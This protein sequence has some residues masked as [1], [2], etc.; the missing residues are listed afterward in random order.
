MKQL[1]LGTYTREEIAKEFNLETSN[2]NFA[3]KVKE[4]LTKWGYSFEYSRKQ[5]T[6]TRIPTTADEKL[7]EILIREYGLDIQTETNAF[8]AFFYS[9]VV[10][11]EFSSMPWEERAEFLED[12]FG[13]CVSDRTLRSW[14]S[15]LLQT[16]T[17]VKDDS[18]K[19]R[20]ITGYYQG[21]KYR[22]LVDGDKELEK[23]ADDYRK[24]MKELLDKYKT[25]ENKEKWSL[26]RKELWNKYKCCIYYCNTLTTTAFDNTESLEILQEMV[27]LV[28]EIAEREPVETAVVITSSIVTI[29]KKDGFKF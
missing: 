14:C 2:K 9:I 7:A 3:R 23:L 29:P 20:W 5:I 18:N 1:K 16:S 25:I 21:E 27:E 22:E 28:N 26:V 4:T 24:S 17:V 11:P 8:A 15:R 19:T 10:F 6:I 12:E 13:V